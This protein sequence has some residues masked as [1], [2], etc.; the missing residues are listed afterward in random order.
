MNNRDNM[1]MNPAR[2][3]E[4]NMNGDFDDDVYIKI[5]NSGRRVKTYH[6]PVKKIKTNQR[7][8][9]TS[10]K[11]FKNSYRD[12]N[13]LYH[14]R[15]F[16]RNISDFVQVEDDESTKRFYNN[17][18]HLLSEIDHS[19]RR[20]NSQDVSI[21]YSSSKSNQ[22]R[23]LMFTPPKRVMITDILAKKRRYQSPDYL[24]RV[25]IKGLL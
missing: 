23:G 2:N 25:R 1:R 7:K 3:E 6:T 9:N 14:N 24:N 4:R 10:I 16:N 22:N 5:H 11:K 12:Y 15:Y 18:N 20:S 8:N 19:R 17:R 21:D 13:Q